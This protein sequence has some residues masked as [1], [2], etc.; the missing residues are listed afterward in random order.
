[1]RISRSISAVDTHVC[2]NRLDTQE[3]LARSALM[4]EEMVNAPKTGSNVI[5]FIDF[6]RTT[7]MP[8]HKAVI[9]GVKP[10]SNWRLVADLLF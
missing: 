5:E 8:E 7:T 9:P 2:G 10:G 3:Y 1:M 4:R 6:N